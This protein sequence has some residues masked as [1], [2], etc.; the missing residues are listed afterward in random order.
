MYMVDLRATNCCRARAIGRGHPGI[1]A[2]VPV[3]SLDDVRMA[4]IRI[5]PSVHR[6]PLLSSRTLD[7]MT[8][9][10]VILKAENFQRT[11]SFKL[12]GVVNTL[13][14][15]TTRELKSGVAASSSGNHG[16]A[17][18]FAA[19]SF[20][21]HATVLMPTDA[22]EAKLSAVRGYGAEVVT[23]NRYDGSLEDAG[24]KLATGRGLTFV[25]PYDDDRVI[26][27][28]G[29]VAVEVVEEAGD[30]DAIVVPVGGGALAAGCAVV[31]KALKPRMRVIGVEPRAGSDTKQSLDRGHRVT[32]AVPHTIAD[33]LQLPSPGEIAF[34]HIRRLVDDIVLVDDDEIID[35]MAFAFDRLKIV[36]E[37]SGAI[38]LAAILTGKLD[39]IAGHCIAAVLSGGNVGAARFASL[40]AGSVVAKDQPTDAA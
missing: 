36:V 27:G 10:R 35:A 30:V 24:V 32:I 12:R 15:L 5:A 11:G 28:Q 33:G 17:V 37:P 19:R 40:I 7:Q 4:A 34:E 2:R 20:G 25:H 3:I 29:T 6:T 16:Q 26:A 23:W 13:A 21:T 14:M 22:P 31:A 1:Q 9:A 8:G 18:A 38:S 39:G